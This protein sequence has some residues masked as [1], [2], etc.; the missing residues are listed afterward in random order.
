MGSSQIK[1]RQTGRLNSRTN[2]TAKCNGA[3]A[4]TVLVYGLLRPVQKQPAAYVT[5]YRRAHIS[6]E[7]VCDHMSCS[8]LAWAEKSVANSLRAFY[9]NN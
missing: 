3:I 4:W 5:H 1:G 9:M 7:I 8:H 6:P 2:Y